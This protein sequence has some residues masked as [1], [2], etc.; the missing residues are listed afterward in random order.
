MELDIRVQPR[1]SRN[2]VEIDGDRPD[3]KPSD[4]KITVRVTAAPESGKA[5]DAVVALLAKRLGV[6]KRSIQIVRGH[7]SR[8]KRISIDG[9]SSKESLRRLYT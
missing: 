7:R 8:V 5:N 4:M 1:A 6:P 9:I 2:A 3:V